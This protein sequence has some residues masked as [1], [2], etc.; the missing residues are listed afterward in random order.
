MSCWERYKG[1]LIILR[2]NYHA[3]QGSAN[4]GKSRG[5]EESQRV[6]SVESVM[7]TLTVLQCR[8]VIHALV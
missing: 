3:P 2:Q 4:R 7:V 1:F 6:L 8:I 5:Y